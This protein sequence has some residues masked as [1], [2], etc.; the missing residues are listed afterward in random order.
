[1]AHAIA[2]LVRAAHRSKLPATILCGFLGSGKTTLLR[3]LLR[4]APAHLRLGVLVNDVSDLEVDGDLVREAERL[5]EA[6]GTLVSLYDGS[7]S[8]SRREAFREALARLASRDDL[9]HLLIETSGSTHPWPLIEDVC[10]HASLELHSLITLLDARSLVAD[11]GG[12]AELLRK[13][14]QNEAQGLRS[15]ENLLVEQLQFASLIVLTKAERVPAADLAIVRKTLEIL[16]PGARVLTASY[17]K[18]DTDLL[19]T[20]GFDLSR[21]QNL[22][23]DLPDADLGES[24]AYDIGHTV[25]RDERPLHPRRFWTCFREQLGLGIHRSKG[26]MWMASRPREVLLWNQSGGSIE[27]ELMAYWK[28]ELVKNPDGKLL[29]QEI[30]QLR[31]WLHGTH[32]VFGDRMNELTLIGTEHDRAIF[33]RHLQTC[34]CTDEEIRHWQSG[35]TFDDPWPKTLRQV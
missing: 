9:D 5:S 13:L 20:G 22:A 29:P 35:G 26:F 10:Q 24:E 31:E 15:A 14:V 1:M 23:N 12:G 2:M 19:H 17:G 4:E 8:G 21:A 25:V 3:R 28:A 18:A 32:P 6:E 11:H 27:M 7:S 34:F 30:A 33:I 16:H